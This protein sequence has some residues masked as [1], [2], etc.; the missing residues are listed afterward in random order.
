MN[1]VDNLLQCKD[2]KPAMW[3]ILLEHLAEIESAKIAGKKYS[4]MAKDFGVASSTF[5]EG[6]SRARLE[7]D[8]QHMP[9]PTPKFAPQLPTGNNQQTQHESPRQNSNHNDLIEGLDRFAAATQ[10]LKT[11]LDK[12]PAAAAARIKQSIEAAADD[13]M[14][15][16]KESVADTV[17]TAAIEL[18][19]SRP[20]SSAHKTVLAAAAAVVIS[21]A[22][23]YGLG[24]KSIYYVSNQQA[25][26]EADRW[27]DFSAA[28][29]YSTP[30][31]RK[32]VA[33]FYS[34][35]RG[36]TANK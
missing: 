12:H 30:E 34:R 28:Y 26:H 11:S 5:S 21:L 13:A 2:Q 14:N 33:S 7:R 17:A 15:Q 4:E 29:Q 10:E 18:E 16:I 35:Y 3:E 36:N 6:L 20:S 1:S 24:S 22:V 8:K 9:I 32:A 25:A 27:R 19:K 23:G 31:E